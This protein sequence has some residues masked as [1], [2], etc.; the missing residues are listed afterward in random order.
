MIKTY[1]V[2]CAINKLT[3]ATTLY[4]RIYFAK[5]ED[6]IKWLTEEIRSDLHQLLN[7]VIGLT[8]GFGMRPGVPQLQ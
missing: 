3:L 7:L 6:I 1:S 5:L 8:S 2:R 4:L